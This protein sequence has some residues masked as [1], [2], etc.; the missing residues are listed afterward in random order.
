MGYWIVV[1]DDE[2]LSLTNAKRLLESEDMKVSCLCSGNDLMKFM[3][4]KS[5]D[6]ILLDILMPDMD[7]FETYHALRQLEEEE[8]RPKTPV[9]FLTGENNK[10]TER[11][12]L[13]A[14]ASDFIRKP[15][16]KDV[17]RKRIKNTIINSRT[18]K[19]LEKEA[20]LDKLT[21]FLNKESGTARISELC[22]GKQGMLMIMDLDNFK[23]VNDL[24]GHDMGDRVLVAFSDIV[25]HSIRADDVVSRIGGDEFMAFFSDVYDENA[26]S[27]LSKRL[28]EELSDKAAELMGNDH[29][30]PLGISIGAAFAPKHSKEYRLLFQ[31]ADSSLYRVKQNGKHG[32]GI[33]DSDV[34]EGDAG[35]DLEKE[36]E[37]ITR[38]MGERREA[39]GAMLLGQDAFS[40]N[41]RFIM[42]FIKRYGGGAARILFSL[43]TN[44]KGVLF[45]EIMAE[46]AHVLSTSLRR[47]D[48]IF[49]NRANQFFVVLPMIS[50]KDVDGVIERVLNAWKQNGY[51]ERVQ[52]NTTV[53][54]IEPDEKTESI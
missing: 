8:N 41:F 2:P 50:L 48:I 28:N 38:I 43:T 49:Q 11:R 21:G 53:A 1:V 3:R 42:R 14:G 46:F 33:Y 40:W 20:S 23:L 17:L 7:G 10:E 16:D 32:Y 13:K 30:I 18:I 36:I 47:S 4:K 27:S 35:N 12:G 26:I 37:R 54:M 24:F 29:D 34:D 5:P 22:A 25:R 39:K 15:F 9:I 52:L 31:Y 6:L 51:N 19:H 45:S 44:E